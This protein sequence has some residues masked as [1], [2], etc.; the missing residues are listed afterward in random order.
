MSDDMTGEQKQK[1]EA[2]RDD[3]GSMSDDM[4]G[5]QKEAFLAELRRQV[6]STGTPTTARDPVNQ[7]MIRHWCDAMDDANPIYTDPDA[8]RRGPH[9]EITAATGHAQR[10]DDGR[11][12]SQGQR[13]PGSRLRGVRHAG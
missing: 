2:G 7:P 5:E 9:G 6:G 3:P 12:R 8:A 11:Q 13:P 4:T 1:R 10:L